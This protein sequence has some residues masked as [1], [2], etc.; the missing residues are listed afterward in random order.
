V[1]DRE[2]HARTRDVRIA[3]KRKRH[4]ELRAWYRDLKRAPCSDWKQT[5]PPQVM[6]WD[7]LPG[8]DKIADV[9]NLL[10][11][12]HSKEA[13]LREIAKCELVCANCHAVRSLKRRGA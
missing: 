1:Y 13:I 10:V 5:F 6:A 2:Y 4:S 7:H 8:A 9:A 11:R 3:Q 12:S